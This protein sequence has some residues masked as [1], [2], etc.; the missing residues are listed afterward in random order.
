MDT[1][2]LDT[3]I[4]RDWIWCNDL[5]NE[6]RYQDQPN[7]KEELLALF[8]NLKKLSEQQKCD[9]GVSTQIFTDAGD[10]AQKLLEK[11]ESELETKIELESPSITTFPI[12]YPIV[13][14][15]KSEITK[16]FET[17][18]PGS[19]PDDKKYLSNRKDALQL[20][21]HKVTKRDYFLT[22]DKRILFAKEELN[23]NYGIKVL[24]LES[25]IA[26]SV[27]E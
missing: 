25:Y 23:R 13:M 14:P 20:Y 10:T 24:D 11:M 7:K 2:T 17:V 12:K 4:I 8:R 1:L 5:S 22:S 21:A 16:I 18:F 26:Q 19:R 15:N 3:N 9:L 27:Q 6:S